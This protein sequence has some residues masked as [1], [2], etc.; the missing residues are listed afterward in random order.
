M[1]VF[2]KGDERMVYNLI[3]LDGGSGRTMIKRFQVLSVTRDREYVLTKGT[4]GSKVL[5]FT[6]NA[7]GEA[8]IVTVFLTAGAKARVKVFDFDFKDLEIKGRVAKGNILT[9]YPVR[10][11][12][13][14][15]KAC[16]L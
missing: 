1:A 4:K 7:N 12:N 16:P 15:W 3:Y 2:R 9:K 14:K 10:K 8:E 6:A 11:S 5:Y 13:L